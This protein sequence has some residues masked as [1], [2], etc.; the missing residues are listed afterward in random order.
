MQAAE[1][2]ERRRQEQQNEREREAQRKLEAE[3]RAAEQRQRAVSGGGC[4]AWVRVA[5][6]S[7]A[8]QSLLD[9][10]LDHQQATRLY[11]V[12]AMR[13]VALQGEWAENGGELPW[14]VRRKG[15]AACEPVIPSP[16]W[17]SP[18]PMCALLQQ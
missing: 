16:S 7:W 14:A 15:R 2:A 10:W 5:L 3:R 12:A 8:G 4:A 18:T 17:P 1:D 6:P 9:V 11:L 13:L